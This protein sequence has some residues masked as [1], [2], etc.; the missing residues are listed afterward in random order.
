MDHFLASEI[1]TGHIDGPFSIS[2][3]HTIFKG[4]FH[5][6]PLGL[7]EKPGSD[8]LCMIHHHSKD[9]PFGHS[10]NGWLDASINAMKYYSAADAAEFVSINFV[11]I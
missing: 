7:V 1:A 10:T 9:D 11:F 2:Q 4:H 8:M 5:T 3:A 6:A